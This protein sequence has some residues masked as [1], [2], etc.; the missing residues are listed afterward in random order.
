MEYLNN[1]P[2]KRVDKNTTS[3]K[4]KED[5]IEF[6]KDKQLSSCLE[7]GTNRGWTTRV[8][9]FLFDDV[10]T[11]EYSTK[12]VQEAKQH[13]GDRDNITFHNIDARLPWNI[14][15]EKFDIIFIDCIHSRE[16]VL[17]DIS[18]G[19]KYSPKYIVFDD[20]GL[21]EEVP[22]VKE[23]VLDF[24]EHNKEFDIEITYVG[25]PAGSE[26][27]IGRRLVDWEGVI[28]SI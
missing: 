12:L 18:Q 17:S 21:P 4:F 8:L 5:V 10:H 2:D 27:R 24:L 11:I 7:V 15:K 13:N 1:I 20:Y 19:L 26:P 28:L 9:S 25:E 6:F 16:A 14:N 23:A 22:S 3:L